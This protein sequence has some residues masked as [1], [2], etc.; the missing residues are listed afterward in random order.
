MSTA[1]SDAEATIRELFRGPRSERVE[2]LYGYEPFPY[3]EDLLNY[4]NADAVTKSAVKPGR[5]VGKT[6]VG[7]T[8]AADEFLTN[9]DVMILGPFE[10]TVSEMMEAFKNQIAHARQ[11][12]AGSDVSLTLETDNEMEYESVS[13]GRV[14]AK[15]VGTKGTQIRG[16]N[17]NVVLVDEAAYIKDSIF[18]EVIEP[19]F[20][21]HDTYQFYLFSTPAGKSGYFYDAVEGSQADEW[22]SPHWPS[23]ISPLIS[24]EFLRKK[25]EQLDSMTFAQEYLGEFVDEGDTLFTHK[26]VSDLT[27][28][29]ELTGAVWLGV[30]IAREG[31]DRTVYAAVDEHGTVNILDSEDTSTMDGVLGRIKDLHREHGFESVI[32]EENSMGGGVVDF[33]HDVDVIQPF[34]SSTKSKHQLYKQLQRDVEAAN[35][36]LPSHRRLLN[37]LSS[38]EYEFTQHG[39]MK[40]SHPDGG[41]DDHADAVAFANWGRNGNGQQTNVTRRNAR[42]SMQ[43]GKL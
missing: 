18:T 17:P 11:T 3:Q 14:R 1:E 28:D 31:T 33:G 40:V 23:R 16:K 6:T 29:T 13:G 32:V 8:I 42:V 12:V 38:L 4:C 43:K 39:Y 35:L 27:G 5:Q 34:K 9:S 10:D 24:E 25:E 30:D 19:F 20:S 2:P 21:T 36:T 7:G 41:H 26:Q 15:T 22:Y 37:E